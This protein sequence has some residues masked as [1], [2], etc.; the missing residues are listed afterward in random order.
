[1]KIEAF[2][3]LH[4]EFDALAQQ[5]KATDSF[6]ERQALLKRVRVVLTETQA[7]ISQSQ[8]ELCE[9]MRFRSVC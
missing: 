6:V 1:M 4:A 7:L 5:V 3:V 8:R 2:R 9:K